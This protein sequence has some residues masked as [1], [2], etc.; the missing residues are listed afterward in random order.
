LETNSQTPQ[1][2]KIVAPPGFYVFQFAEKDKRGQTISTTKVVRHNSFKGAV[3]ELKRNLIY[4]HSSES[5]QDFKI[6][7]EGRWDPIETDPR[8]EA[9]GKDILAK[10]RFRLSGQTEEF[11]DKNVEEEKKY[12]FALHGNNTGEGKKAYGILFAA[13]VT[14]IPPSFDDHEPGYSGPEG[15][16]YLKDSTGRIIAVGI[17]EIETVA[18]TEQYLQEEYQSP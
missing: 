9:I 11:D 8:T 14:F 6:Y 18:Q 2:D 5:Y 17:T 1:P 7:R 12:R 3:R 10:T 16:P 4:I 15:K 13:G